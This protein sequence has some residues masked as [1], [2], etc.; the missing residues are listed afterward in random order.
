MSRTACFSGILRCRGETTA[1]R[2]D[3]GRAADIH[4]V[5]QMAFEERR[6]RR[7]ALIVESAMA[8]RRRMLAGVAR[9][10][11]E[12]E[13]TRRSF[14]RFGSFAT[15]RATGS[16]WTRSSAGCRCRGACWSGDFARGC[17][18][19]DQQRDRPRAAQPRRRAADADAA[20]VEGRRAE[21]GVREY[22]VH[23]RR[24]PR[25]ARANAQLVPGQAPW[26]R[27]RQRCPLFA[28]PDGL[29]ARERRH[30]TD[31]DSEDFH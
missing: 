2:T 30:L 26:C 6:P 1:I 3:V 8:P 14:L 12:H 20:G 18:A 11:H 31:G 22:V 4:R 27:G 17:G 9:Y 19:F 7:V 5:A 21:G 16:V 13:P 10:M 24:V 15:T 29:A 23:A 28:R 25:E